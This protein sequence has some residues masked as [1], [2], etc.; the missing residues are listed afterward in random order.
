MDDVQAASDTQLEP[1]E[2]PGY[3]GWSRY[4][5]RSSTS[6]TW[7]MD[8]WLLNEALDGVRDLRY[9]ARNAEEDGDS[10]EADE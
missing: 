7:S 5:S 4:V 8:E 10:A 1:W 9:A 6:R 2:H 3:P